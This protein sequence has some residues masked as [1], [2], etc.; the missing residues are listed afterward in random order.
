MLVRFEEPFCWQGIAVQEYKTEGTH[1]RAI[2][3]QTLLRHREGLACEVRYF[4]VQPGGYSSLERHQ[5]AHAV[6]VLRGTGRALVGESIYSLRPFDV[7][8]IP[9]GCWHQFRAEEDVLGFLCL[10]NCHRDRPE[11]PTEADLEQLRRH[12]EIAAFI[13]I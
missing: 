8:Y 9:P 12:P 4:E 1:F 3:R 5:H 11:L 13:R 6:I 7:L 10:V 2:T